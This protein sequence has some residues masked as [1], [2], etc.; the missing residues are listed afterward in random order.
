MFPP[1]FCSLD[2]VALADLTISFQSP[3]SYSNDAWYLQVIKRSLEVWGSEEALE[4]AKENRQ[5]NR[6]K[7]KQKKFDKKVKGK[8]KPP[9]PLSTAGQ[10]T[11]LHK[12][13]FFQTTFLDSTQTQYI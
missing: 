13:A 3:K 11:G 1:G 12:L 7:M 2:T 6:E 9:C 4:E 8:C 5:D 10:C